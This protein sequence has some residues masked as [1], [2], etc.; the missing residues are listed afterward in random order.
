MDLVD[1][2]VKVTLS[3]A[4]MRMLASIIG[5]DVNG[6]ANRL[7]GFVS[8][9][10]EEYVTMMLGQKVFRRGADIQEYRLY[11]LI[12]HV[13]NGIPDEQ[14]I[15]RLFQ[16]TASESRSL[17]RSVMSKYQYVLKDAINSSLLEVLRLAGAKEE[18]GEYYVRI[19]NS[20]IVDSLNVL[21]SVHDGSLQPVVKRRGCVS[22]YEISPASYEKLCELMG[23]S[24]AE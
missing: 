13:F 4:D 23:L 2:D 16:L 15:C 24:D 3:E 5:C 9:S 12:K 22:E 11:L 10:A 20:S 6:L 14:Q 8:A 19:D 1:L 7:G 21:L 17:I 18:G